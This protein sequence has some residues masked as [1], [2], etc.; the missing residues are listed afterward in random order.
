[1]ENKHLF[2]R[3]KSIYILHSILNYISDENIKYK[4]FKYSKSYQKK[5]NIDLINYKEKYLEKIG[6]NID[7]YLYQE[8]YEKKKFDL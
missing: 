2:E 8:I 3:I 4:L 7:D 6:F 1:M 5:L